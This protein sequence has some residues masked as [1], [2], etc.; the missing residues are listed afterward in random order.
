MR[1]TV[2]LL[3]AGDCRGI[4]RVTQPVMDAEISRH[5]EH[6]AKLVGVDMAAVLSVA[7]SALADAGG[8]RSA[9]QR[10]AAQAPCR[11][12]PDLDAAALAYACRCYLPLVQVPPRGL[13]SALGHRP[14]RHADDWLAGDRT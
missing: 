7:R 13:W 2:H 10:R 4:R 11:R 3:H 1:G 9:H 6:K 8:H 5:S 14:D 12:V